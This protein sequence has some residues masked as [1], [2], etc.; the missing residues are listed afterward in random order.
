MRNTVIKF[1]ISAIKCTIQLITEIKIKT[2]LLF[3]Y[4]KIICTGRFLFYKEMS[5]G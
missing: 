3:K 5:N 1:D 2:K 4:L